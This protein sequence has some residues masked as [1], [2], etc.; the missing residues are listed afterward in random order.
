MW[1][2]ILLIW[3]HFVSD[4]LF[5]SHYMSVNKSKNIWVLALHAAIYGLL[6]MF[7]GAHFAII[8]ALLH[9]VVD[10]FTSK[11]TSYLW[12]K[13]KTHWFFVVIGADQAIH[14]TLLF[15]TYKLLI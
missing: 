14:L 8:T 7:F 10:F 1:T 3:V 6:F 11:A 4:F 5:Q 15:V 9:F 13:E 12:K 2:F